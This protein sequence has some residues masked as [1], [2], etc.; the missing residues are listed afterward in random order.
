M[1][2]NYVARYAHHE[3]THWWF[4]ARLQLLQFQIARILRKEGLKTPLRVLNIGAGGGATSAMLEAFGAVKSVEYDADLFIYCRDTLGLDV[5]QAS[6]TELPYADGA[7]DL[8]CVFDVLEHVEDDVKALSEMH[9]VTRA[10]GMLFVTVPAFQALWSSHDRANN[11]LRRYTA[12]MLNARARSVGLRLRLSSYFNFLLFPPIVLAR[13]ADR[14]RPAKA[15][16][17]GDFDRYQ[18]GGFVN[19]LLFRIFRSERRLMSLTRLP[20]GLSVFAAYRRP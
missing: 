1:E 15:V 14:L 18:A 8:V 19:S 12:P 2:K 7:F 3:R 6:V 16:E 5:D 9:R 11:H 4:R 20:F 10:G 13:L 17:P